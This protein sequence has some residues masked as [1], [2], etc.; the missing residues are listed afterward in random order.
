V[1]AHQLQIVSD[2]SRQIPCRFLSHLPPN[3]QEYSAAT[4]STIMHGPLSAAQVAHASFFLRRIHGLLLGKYMRTRRHGV[5]PS[6]RPWPVGPLR[7]RLP[8]FLFLF[9]FSCGAGIICAAAQHG[10]TYGTGAPRRLACDPHVF[11][12]AQQLCGHVVVSLGCLSFT[13]ART[14]GFAWGLG[15]LAHMHTVSMVR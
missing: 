9:L 5:F 11:I 2:W 3:K 8:W 12:C 15:R 10:A 1:S 4:C 13:C 14:E 7:A 6:L